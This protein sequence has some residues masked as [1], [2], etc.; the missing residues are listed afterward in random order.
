MHLS[1]DRVRQS[2]ALGGA[3]GKPLS[4]WRQPLYR[5][6]ALLEIGLSKTA[7]SKQKAQRVPFYRS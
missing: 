6:Q 2:L 5:S 1:E 7:V 4:N 3:C